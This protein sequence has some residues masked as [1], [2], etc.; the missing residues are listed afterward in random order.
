MV[1]DLRRGRL[2]LSHQ[3][4]CSGEEGCKTYYYLLNSCLL[5]VANYFHSHL[6][7]HDREQVLP[8]VLQVQGGVIRGGEQQG[9][10]AW[11][12]TF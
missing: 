12:M 8:V 6:M 4:L 11:G 7:L 9:L 10:P 1:L 3:L 5:F 2:M